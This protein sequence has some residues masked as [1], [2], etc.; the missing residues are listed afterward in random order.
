MKK[1][2][3]FLL[4]VVVS[5]DFLISSTGITG[6]FAVSSA[7]NY[8]ADLS[9]ANTTS[10]TF[11]QKSDVSHTVAPVK[12]ANGI[13]YK[14]YYSTSEVPNLSVYY[15]SVYLINTGY[16]YVTDFTLTMVFRNTW[17]ADEMR[18][19][20]VIYH[21]QIDASGNLSGY[22]MNLR[23]NGQSAYSVITATPTFNDGAKNNTAYSYSGSDSN[24]HTIKITMNGMTSSHYID[25]ALIS[26]QNYNSITPSINQTKGGFAFIVNK[27]C[28]ELK[29][30]TITGT[31]LSP[32]QANNNITVEPNTAAVINSESDLIS[33]KQRQFTSAILR[34]DGDLNVLD[35][36]DNSLGSL[37]T[38]YTTY[39]K[40]N[41]V[42]IVNIGDEPT[43]NLISF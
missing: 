24:W 2:F 35:D 19:F 10:F 13:S 1:L 34:V 21:T 32:E 39:I 8:S 29:S 12:T 4:M 26:T 30:L 11:Y 22:M 16:D 43:N 33:A 37:S 41:V 9:S 20:G 23:N 17:Y 5:F 31:D 15:G 27:G 14:N 3:T 25:G 18:W 36:E 40:N 7:F 6:I 42:P 28:I 38:V